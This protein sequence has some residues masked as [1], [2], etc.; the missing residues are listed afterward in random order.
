MLVLTLLQ[1][2]GKKVEKALALLGAIAK[3]VEA[4]QSKIGQLEK[5]LNC[6]KLLSDIVLTGVGSF[7]PS[8]HFD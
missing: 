4:H 6:S 2:E 3:S 7:L 8:R 5:V 1:R